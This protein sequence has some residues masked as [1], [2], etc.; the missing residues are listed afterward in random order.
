MWLCRYPRPMIITYNRGNEFLGHVL[1]NDLIENE[2][3]IKPKCETK[4]NA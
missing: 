4:E 2:Y 1:K 3:G